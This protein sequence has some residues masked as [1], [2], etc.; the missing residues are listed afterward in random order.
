MTLS[1]KRLIRRRRFLASLTAFTAMLA[2]SQR[3]ITKVNALEGVPKDILK[4]KISHLEALAPSTVE[5]L[6][7]AKL[8]AVGY[9]PKSKDQWDEQALIQLM[10]FQYKYQLRANGQLDG[11]TLKAIFE[12]GMGNVIKQF[13]PFAF[14]SVNEILGGVI[15]ENGRVSGQGTYIWIKDLGKYMGI[16]SHQYM[17]NGR[18]HTG[19]DVPVK[20]GHPIHLLGTELRVWY[21]EGGAGLVIDQIHPALPGVLIRSFHC[22][23]AMGKHWTQYRDQGR[24]SPSR[25]AVFNY[26]PAEIG[27]AQIGTVGN[28]GGS[29]GPHLHA[30]VKDIH[31]SLPLT[32]D[33][34][35]PNRVRIGTNILQLLLN[36]ASDVRPALKGPASFTGAVLKDRESL[37]E[38]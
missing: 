37:E 19:V 13:R 25:A 30:E 29:R 26:L 21:E 6:A 34:Y 16:I 20:T 38:F 5:S 24:S 1:T 23:S 7:L 31:F 28:T 9:M 22:D 15:P 33:Q 14:W 2:I 32:R 35:V 18:P 36:G 12:G 4:V 3:R 10:H 11:D 27:L 8:K 17:R